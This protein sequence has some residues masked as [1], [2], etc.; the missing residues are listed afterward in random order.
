VACG[1]GIQAASTAVASRVLLLLCEAWSL[2]NFDAVQSRTEVPKTRIV[3]AWVSTSGKKAF[4]IAQ[5]NRA[6]RIAEPPL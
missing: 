3:R 5:H 1:A 2:C 4:A 6:L